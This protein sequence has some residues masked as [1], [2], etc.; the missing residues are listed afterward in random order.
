[1]NSDL[2]LKQR[3]WLQL[4]LKLGNATEAAMQVYDCKERETAAVI[5]H[6]N[7]RKLNYEEFMEEA[8]ITDKKLQDSIMEGL[9]AN[10]VISAMNTGKQASGATADFIDVPDFAVRHKYLET[11]LKLK[12]RL[13]ERKDITSNDEPIK[14]ETLNDEQLDAIIESKLRKSG[15]SISSSREGKT[16]E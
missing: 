14:F 3:K 6:E 12:K 11:A 4:Y 5:G 13:V 7:L 15:T 9:D 2:T 10:R 16:D 8:G 1:M